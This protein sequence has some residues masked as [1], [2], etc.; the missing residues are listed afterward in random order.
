MK[1]F[2]KVPFLN[3]VVYEK[4]RKNLVEVFGGEFREMIVGGAALNKDVEIFL[5]KIGFPLTIGYG[6]TECGP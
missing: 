3:K 5:R 4:V 1:T 6:M 2:L